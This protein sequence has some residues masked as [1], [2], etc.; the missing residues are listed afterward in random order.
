MGHSVI[1]LSLD[2]PPEGWNLDQFNKHIERLVA[3]YRGCYLSMNLT[4]MTLANRIH[5]RIWIFRDER[6]KRFPLDPDNWLLL[7]GCF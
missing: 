4:Q 1:D 6:I 3:M 5:E 7:E 2:Q